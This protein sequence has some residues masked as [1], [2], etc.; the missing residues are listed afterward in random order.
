VPIPALLDREEVGE[1]GRVAQVDRA[2]GRLLAVVADDE[3]LPHA[4]ADVAVAQNHQAAVGPSD[5]GTAAQDEGG[6]E[7]RRPLRGQRLRALAVDLQADPGE[8]PGVAE[9]Q[10]LG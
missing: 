8:E 6:R 9:E 7:R 1:V 4:P 2:V 10:A 5:D 3:V